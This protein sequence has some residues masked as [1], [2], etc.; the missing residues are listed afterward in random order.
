[1]SSLV[2]IDK[3]SGDFGSDIIVTGIDD[4]Y[5]SYKIYFKAGATGYNNGVNLFVTKGGVIQTGANYKHAG[6]NIYNGAAIRYRRATAGTQ[7]SM[8]NNNKEN[9]TRASG[10]VTFTAELFNFAN[11]SGYDYITANGTSQ[12]N[13]QYNYFCPVIHGVHTV[14]SASDG[15]AIRQNSGSSMSGELSLYG[16][17]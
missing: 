16:V 13:D 3:F 9:N 6:I 17:K 8:W 7:I 15:F 11:S 5:D 1:M 4:T 14:A 12:S 2:L 10:L